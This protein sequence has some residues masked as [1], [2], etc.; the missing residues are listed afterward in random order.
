MSK[1]ITH[2]T[3]CGENGCRFLKGG[4]CIVNAK[5]QVIEICSMIVCM[6]IM[7][8]IFNERPV[9]NICRHTRVFSPRRHMASLGIYGPQKDVARERVAFGGVQ[10]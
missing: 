6:F 1:V 4:N 5:K 9:I 2:A 8:A 3:P 7:H 10:A